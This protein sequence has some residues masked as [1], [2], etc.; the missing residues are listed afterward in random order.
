MARSGLGCSVSELVASKACFLSSLQLFALMS[1]HISVVHLLLFFRFFF[2]IL[3]YQ[4]LAAFGIYG[5]FLL[6]LGEFSSDF[7][8]RSPYRTYITQTTCSQLLNQ[9]FHEN[10]VQKVARIST[11]RQSLVLWNLILAGVRL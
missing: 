6:D 10:I 5:A 11:F 8:Q 9:A 1:G 4:R 7:F 3:G 2:K